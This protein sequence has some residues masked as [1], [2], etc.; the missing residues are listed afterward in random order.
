MMRMMTMS[1][2]VAELT[3]TVENLTKK[4]KERFERE[5]AETMERVKTML[6]HHE[7]KCARISDSWNDF[8]K[9]TQYID[10]LMKVND[11]GHKVHDEIDEA[12]KKLKE[13]AYN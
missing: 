1:M 6:E 8:Q 7:W 12:V 9:Q 2:T 11:S 13:L 3:K 5:Q 4:V 10:M